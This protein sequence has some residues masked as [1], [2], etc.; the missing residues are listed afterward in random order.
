MKN[1]YLN[2]LRDNNKLP[3]CI[4]SKMLDVI[5]ENDAYAADELVSLSEEILFQIAS[6]GISIYLSQPKQKQV[7]NDFILQLFTS[8]SNS[9]NAG[10][11]YRWAANMIKDLDDDLSKK[12]YPL[13]WRDG[14]LNND[15]NRLSKLR[16][17]VMHGFFVLP[18]SKNIEEANHIGNILR[19][20]TDL[21]LFSLNIASSH[22]FLSKEEKVIFFN[23]NWSISEDQWQLYDKSYDF[24]ELSKDIRYELSEKYDEDQLKLVRENT[25]SDEVIKSISTFINTRT[26]GFMSVFARPNY[27]LIT[28]YANLVNYLDE[29]EYIK[30]FY[31]LDSHGVNITDDFLLLK[32]AKRLAK[33]TGSDLLRKDLKKS[34]TQLRK[35][36]TKK[37][38]VVI[39]SVHISLFSSD[40]LLQLKDLFYENNILL[41]A[42][43]IHY[44]YL[45]QYFNKCHKIESDPYI[46]KNKDWKESF[47]N[48]LRF[49]GPNKDVNDEAKI[50]N[51]LYAVT[52]NLIDELEREKLVVARRF[53]D[54]YNYSSEYVHE[55]FSILHPFLNTKNMHFDRDELN[56][57][58]NFPKEINESSLVFFALGRRDFKL[59]YQHK[60]LQL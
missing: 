47:E 35:K 55:A 13:F 42:F 29:R 30:V 43:G 7:F 1:T 20:I 10:P 39:N 6:F 53:S 37:I 26:R 50:Y 16:N 58:Y 44:P 21:N 12:V 54:K 34:L 33:E 15:I 48:Y 52:L 18:A 3:S 38:V 57:N 14:V 32:L 46:P 28:D 4:K 24:G 22:H 31:S 36:C 60:V 45:D 5:N 17:T 9:Y 56:F 49:K 41:V 59:E 8:K 23:N 27:N 25:N 11:L 40:H 51:K 2:K 19:Q